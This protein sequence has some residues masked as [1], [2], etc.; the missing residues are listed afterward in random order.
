[1]TKNLVITE[2]S[3]DIYKPWV[4]LCHQL[5][6]EHEL[7]SL[8]AECDALLH[9]P[10]ETAFLLSLDGA[11]VGFINLSIRADRVP[12]AI[13][14]PVGYIEGIYVRPRHRHRGLAKKLV[15][16]A[17]HWLVA[18][19]CQEVASDAEIDNRV[20]QD[21]HEAIGFTKT[22]VLVHYVKLCEG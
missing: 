8:K 15:A 11:Y 9:N 19:G 4:R 20:S 1:M 7:D 6:P 5:W 10:K 12:G 22:R 13:H 21:W 18:H 3:P 16:H 14:S 2:V 17:M